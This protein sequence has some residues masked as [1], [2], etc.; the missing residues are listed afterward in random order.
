VDP[1]KR[2]AEV[3]NPGGECDPISE[4]RV[5]ANVVKLR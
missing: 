4:N 5:F 3:L 2:Y 1:L